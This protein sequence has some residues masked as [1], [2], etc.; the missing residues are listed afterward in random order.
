MHTGLD[1]AE[2][3]NAYRIGLSPIMVRSSHV[4]SAKGLHGFYVR[5]QHRARI[6][7]QVTLP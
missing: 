1:E 2:P 3:L 5:Y 6:I 4:A 7:Q